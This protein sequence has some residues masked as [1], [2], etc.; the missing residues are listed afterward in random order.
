VDADYDV[1]DGVHIGATWRIR[2]NYPCVAALSQLT[3]TTYYYN[4]N[5]IITINTSITYKCKQSITFWTGMC[6]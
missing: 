2:L 4:K 1:L 3:L 6:D 5:N